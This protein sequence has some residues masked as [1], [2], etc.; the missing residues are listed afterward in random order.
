M[1]LQLDIRLV[2]SEEADEAIEKPADA[3][4]SA[5]EC[6]APDKRDKAARAALERLERE[7]AFAFWCSELHLCDQT[8]EIAIAILRF[9]KDRK[10]KRPEN[11]RRA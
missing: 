5:V 10:R 2:A 8:A 11:R 1:A 7:R 6:R 9:A 4:L 3:V